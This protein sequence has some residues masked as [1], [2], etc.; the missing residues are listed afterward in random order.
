[1]ATG[2]SGNE[3]FDPITPAEAKGWRGRR[4]RPL[5]LS[6]VAVIALAGGAG[7]GFAATGSSAASASLTSSSSATSA[8]PAASA[9]ASP[10]ASAQ[11][12]RKLAHRRFAGIIGGRILH[13]QVVVPKSGGGYQTVDVQ[14]GQVTA[15]S[16]TS[17]TVK[18]ADGYSATYV[19]SGSTTVD[20][21]SR[22]I[23][24]VKVGDRVVLEAT[25]SGGT[26]TA[27]HILDRTEL[28]ASRKA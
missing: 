20:A 2:P 17:I 25:L 3:P 15:V 26:A 11:A 27:S 1:M 19:V 13:G 10:S 6:G 5:L 14:R 21:Q 8:S 7:V 4:V 12:H 16:S 9:S 24:S 22:G 23:G 28:R 18:S